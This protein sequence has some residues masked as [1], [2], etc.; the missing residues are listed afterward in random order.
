M[1]QMSGLKVRPRSHA[2]IRY[3]VT[4]LTDSDKITYT[5]SIPR[6]DNWLGFQCCGVKVKV[7]ACQIS[8]RVVVVGGDIHVSAWASKC[9]LVPGV[10]LI[11]CDNIT[12]LITTYSST[13]IIKSYTTRFNDM[14][15][16]G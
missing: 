8:E 4:G 9:H 6:L 5:Y 12:T 11:F 3:T 1:V 2:K 7:T 10:C 15:P 16:H 13:K 14:Q